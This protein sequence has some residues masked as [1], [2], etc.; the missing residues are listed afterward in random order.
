MNTIQMSLFYIVILVCAVSII[1]VSCDDDDND[2]GGGTPVL[3]GDTLYYEWV[4]PGPIYLNGMFSGVGFSFDDG[5]NHIYRTQEGGY[6]RVECL[7]DSF[8]DIDDERG[9][10]LNYG[11]DFYTDLDVIFKATLRDGT[12]LFYKPLPGA[13]TRTE[14]GIDHI[15]DD[16]ER[17]VF[18]GKLN[19]A[20]SEMKDYTFTALQ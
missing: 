20:A 11:T 16:R 8:V 17:A 3:S 7:T 1:L 13:I 2:H 6:A 4:V 19:K 5:T 14:H 18:I 10:D 12:I 15:L 9:L